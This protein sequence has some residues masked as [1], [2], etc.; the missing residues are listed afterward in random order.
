[1]NSI[2]VMHGWC[3]EHISMLQEF[4]GKNGE[5]LQKSDKITKIEVKLESFILNY[6]SLWPR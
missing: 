5:T 4:Q 3:T 1:M 6:D 2:V